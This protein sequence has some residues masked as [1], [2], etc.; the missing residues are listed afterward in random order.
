MRVLKSNKKFLKTRLIFIFAIS[1]FSVMFFTACSSMNKDKG[2]NTK[3]WDNF[4]EDN[5]I[6]FYYSDGKSPS[7]QQLKSKY[8]IDKLVSK[9]KDEISKSIKISNW[10]NE[11]LKFSKNSIKSEEDV[12]TILEQYKKGETLSDKEFSEIFTESASSVGIYSRMGELRVKNA[13]HGKK[14]VSFMV[15][16]IWSN[17]YNKWIMIDPVNSCYMT[18]GG[19]PL[20]AVELLKNGIN[21]VEIN[22][23]KDRKK[24]V[25]NMERYMYSYTIAIDNNIHDTVKSNSYITYIPNNELPELKTIKGYIKPTIFVNKDILF[26]ISPKIKY[27]ESK[28]DKKATLII[29]KKNDDGKEGESPSFY[30]AAFKDSVMV[31]EYYISID[32]GDF[33][34]VN[35]Y[36]EIKLKEGSNSIRLS[37]NGKDVVRDITIEYKK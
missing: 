27:K 13:Q 18:K 17:K 7:S 10:L 21:S 37:E 15:S 32:G 30:I 14:D 16:E 8:S 3:K 5:N 24:Y 35:K 19:V 20:S 26:N 11:R 23:V 12:L 34:K 1:L 28:T 36:Y 22:G 9:E 29:S 25:K 33:G 2:V 31:N 6:Q 4:Y